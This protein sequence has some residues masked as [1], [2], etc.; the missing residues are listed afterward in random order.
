LVHAEGIFT[1]ELLPRIPTLVEHIWFITEYWLAYQALLQNRID[2]KS[3][4]EAITMMLN[5]LKPYLT[6]K[7][8]EMFSDIDPVKG[9]YE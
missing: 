3:I 7:G 8:C 4:T 2:Q 9:R 6:E 5:Q 1:E